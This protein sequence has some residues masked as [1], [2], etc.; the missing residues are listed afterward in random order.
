MAGESMETSAAEIRQHAAFVGGPIHDG[1]VQVVDA[2]KVSIGADVMGVLCQ[3]WSFIFQEEH[4]QAK[5]AVA[6]LPDLL[7]MDADCLKTIAEAYESTED[8]NRSMF[9]QVAE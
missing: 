6:K 9:G 4:E 2:S 5:A 7:M 3:A 1:L 8:L